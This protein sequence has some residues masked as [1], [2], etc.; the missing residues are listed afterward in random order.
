MSVTEDDL[1]VELPPQHALL[2]PLARAAERLQE[3][4]YSADQDRD[5]YGKFTQG[6]GG[7]HDDWVQGKHA[8]PTYRLP[9]SIVDVVNPGR[10]T[11]QKVFVGGSRVYGDMKAVASTIDRLPKD[12]L[13]STS[14]THGASAAARGAA[15]ANGLELHVWT[16]IFN[17]PTTEAAFFA[18]DREMIDHADRVISFWDGVS[19]GTDHEVA[20]ARSIGKPVEQYVVRSDSSEKRY[21]PD[22]PRDDHGRFGEGTATEGVATA[23][24]LNEGH[25]PKQLLAIDKAMQEISTLDHERAIVLDSSGKRVYQANGGA[26]AVEFD[27]QAL[28]AKVGPGTT[29]IH[30]HPE[31]NS[32]FSNEDLVAAAYMQAAEAR[33]QTDH[34]IYV[35]RPS[36]DGWPPFT[37]MIRSLEF[38]VGLARTRISSTGSGRTR[39]E[40]SVYNEKVWHEINT[41]VSQLEGFTYF[42][43]P[44]PGRKT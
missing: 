28:A 31:S 5:S 23:G 40:K 15:Q 16:P 12:T 20:Y 44:N 18:R 38:Q 41:K 26:N 7:A 32:S 25:S 11:G 13:L 8:G 39:A 22:Q 1:V 27:V 29:L 2:G 36:A 9:H 6:G 34:W 37:K 30:N 24:A 35:A 17:Q 21:S 3:W 42:R 10:G 43:L 33:L 19:T 4:R 14:A